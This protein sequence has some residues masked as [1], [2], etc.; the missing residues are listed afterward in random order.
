MN[1]QSYI[2]K[3]L[4]ALLP[5]SAL[6]QNLVLTTFASGYDEPIGIEN[7]GDERLFV[8]E[9]KGI[10]QLIDTTGEKT[11]IPFLDIEDKVNDRGNEQGLLGLAFHPNYKSNGLFYLNYTIGSRCHRNSGIQ[12]FQ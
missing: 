3:V 2:L 12:C 5:T 10:I 6:C 11:T 9:Q 1:I 4:C 7:A 8:V